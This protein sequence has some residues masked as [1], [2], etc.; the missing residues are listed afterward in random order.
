MQTPTGNDAGLHQRASKINSGSLQL[1]GLLQKGRGAWCQCTLTCCKPPCCPLSA[2][3]CPAADCRR[4]A[5]RWGAPL[6]WLLAA[7]EVQCREASSALRAAAGGGGGRAA[8]G[9]ATA[10]PFDRFGVSLTP[11]SIALQSQQ[12]AAGHPHRRCWPAAAQGAQL[13]PG[14][15]VALPTTSRFHWHTAREGP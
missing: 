5:S 3:R 15:S 13:Q 9:F 2:A 11:T 1:V 8:A 12:T 4:C 10:C 7:A 14:G 6:P